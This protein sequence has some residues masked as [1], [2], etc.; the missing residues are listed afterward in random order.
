M[1]PGQLGLNPQNL[2]EKKRRACLPSGALDLEQA[3]RYPGRRNS[4]TERVAFIRFSAGWDW[5]SSPGAE[6]GRCWSLILVCCGEERCGVV[7]V[8]C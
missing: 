6:S 7:Q 1:R 4:K 3:N 2:W 5:G 8:G